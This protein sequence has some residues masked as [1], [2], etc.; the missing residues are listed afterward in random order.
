LDRTQPG[1][2]LKPGKRGTPTHATKR[3]GPTLFA[4]L[5]VLD[6][7]ILGRR[8]QRP[9]HRQLSRLLGAIEAAVPAGKLVR[10]VL[11]TDSVQPLRA[12]HQ[13]PKVMAWLD[14]H[15]R[16]TFHLTPTSGSTRRPMPCVPAAPGRSRCDRWLNAVETFFS[17]PTRRRPRRGVVRS[18]V[19]LQAAIHRYI[20]QHNDDPAPFTWTKT[21]DQILSKLNRLN[22]SV[23]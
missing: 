14:R 2:P 20:G 9:R 8:M 19:D 23:H 10:V 16:W 21:T 18:I 3:T 12:T 17:A 1:L 5:D 13:H 6:G 15:P 11:D 4:A 7:T 22:A